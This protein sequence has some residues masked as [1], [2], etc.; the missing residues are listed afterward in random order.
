[1]ISDQLAVTSAA[2]QL[3]DEVHIVS[4]G[5]EGNFW[6]GSDFV[7][8]ENVGQ[9]QSQF[10][11]WGQGLSVGADVLIYACLTALGEMGQNLLDKVAEFTGADVAGSTDLTGAAALGGDWR[12]ERSV[13]EVE[14]TSPF[15]PA[16]LDSYSD[17][18]QIFTVANNNDAGLGSLRE[19]IT[20]ANGNA[21]ADEIRFDPGFFDGSQDVILL[22]S[23]E[24]GI[25]AAEDLTID[26]AF[27]GATNVVVDGNNASRVFNVTGSGNV[28][29]E[30][31]LFRMVMPS[32]EA[33]GFP[34]LVVAI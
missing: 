10:K 9:Y 4:E 30:G 13:G 5:N 19:A 34:V 25:T 21:E 11:G 18:L 27:G 17:T 7:S 20:S 16:V 8:S 26:G 15:L 28:T 14:A 1:L 31:L 3:V 24:L 12:L 6:L 32:V 29:F 33:V 23:G 22:T 2:G